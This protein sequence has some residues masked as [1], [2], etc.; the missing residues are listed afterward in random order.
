[1]AKSD[2]ATRIATPADRTFERTQG[3]WNCKHAVSGKERWNELRLRDLKKAAN[4]VKMFP[5]QGE[6]HP[7]VLNIRKMVD[8]FDHAVAMREAI[9][10][11]GDGV[12]AAGQPVGDLVAANY[13]CHKWSAAQ[14]ASIARAGQ[15]ADDLPEE[16]LEKIDGGK[17]TTLADL[18]SKQSLIKERP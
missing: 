5:K 7:K 3:C 13:L 9:H 18:V 2:E 16:L 15:K 11:T 4:L 6:N 8:L 14:G 1:M 10:C 17:P 12:T